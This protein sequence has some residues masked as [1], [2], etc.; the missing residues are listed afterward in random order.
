MSQ[1]LSRRM[2]LKGL[3]TAVALPWLEAM[4]P[5]YSWASADRKQPVRMAFIYVPNGICMR[6]W[7]PAELGKLPDKLPPILEPLSKLRDDFSIISGLASDKGR[8]PVGHAPA[9]GAYLTAVRPRKTD[10]SDYRAGISVDQVAASRLDGQT[11]LPSLQIG[12]DGS[13]THGECDGYSCA[14]M[15]TLSWRDATTP[16]PQIT[17]PRH[18]FDRLFGEH[19]GGNNAR[20]QAERRSVLDFVREEAASLQTNLSAND[21]RKLDEYFTAIRDIEKR[22]EQAVRMPAPKAPSDFPIPDAKKSPPTWAEHARLL[23]DLITLAFQTDSTRVCTFVFR[24]EFSGASYPDA[25]ITASHHNVSHHGDDPE[26]SA[27]CVAINKHHLTQFAYILNKL[28]ETREGDGSLLDH[29][30]IAYGSGMSDGLRHDKSNLPVLLAGHGGGTLRPGRHLRFA[31][32]TPLANLWVSMLD[33]MDTTVERL[34]DST[35]RLSGL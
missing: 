24:N 9:Q 25:G 15:T 11:R 6:D 13:Q 8:A 34:G 35:G 14:Y 23:G 31:A 16:L 28:K 2:V 1:I 21:R 10:G 12:C 29:C 7:T 18:V 33:R 30:M 32:E 17:N 4:A 26:K 20:R 5:I 3:G 27:Q 19:S 22:I